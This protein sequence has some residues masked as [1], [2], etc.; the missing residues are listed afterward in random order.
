MTADVDDELRFHV[1]ALTNELVAGGMT[2]PAARAEALRRFGDVDRYR[3][4][5]NDVGRRQQ[6]AARF[7]TFFET[8]GQDVA[9]ATRTLVRAPLFTAVAVASLALGIGA[10]AAIF[11]LA[12]AILLHPLPAVREPER[13]ATLASGPQSYP[14]YRDYG[15]QSTAWEGL[16]AFRERPVSLGAGTTAHL[17]RVAIVSGNYFSVLGTP[18]LRG[19]TI[20]PDDDARGAGQRVAVISHGLWQREFA[21]DA[22]VLGRKLELNGTAFTVVGVAPAGFRGPRAVGDPSVWIPI[23]AWPSVATGEF[24]QLDIESRGWGWL[25]VI[26]RLRPGV[27]L[28]AADRELDAIAERLRRVHRPASPGPADLEL[29]PAIQTVMGANAHA[30]TVRFIAV[31]AA[32]AGIALLVACAN[33]ANLQ[34]ARA[35]A[36][37]REIGVRLALGAGRGRLVRQLVTENV[38]LAAL[39]GLA[40]IAVSRLML[41]WASVVSLPGG[42]SVA[43]VAGSVSPRV[44]AFTLAVACVVGVAFGLAP[45]LQASNPELVSALKDARG[46]S[47]RSGLKLRSA[48]V[49]SQ[50]ALCLVLLAGA[51]LF[52]RSLQRALSV[53]LGFRPAGVAVASF[54]LALQRYDSARAQAFYDRLAERMRSVPGVEAVGWATSLPFGG[55]NAIVVRPAGVTF[56]PGETPVIAVTY[57]AGDYFRALRIPI[58]RGRALDERDRAGTPGVAV[59]S[60]AMAARLWSG[61][62]PIGRQFN[63]NI[64]VVGVARDIRFMELR[65]RPEPYLYGS[66]PQIINTL[67]LEPVS[68]AVRASGDL[69]RIH[70]AIR[71]EVRALDERVPIIDPRSLEDQLAMV[72]LPQRVGAML[73][74]LFGVLT[75]VLAAVGVYGVLASVVGRRTREIGIRVALG[76]RPGQVVGMV[77]RQ[78]LGVVAAGVVIGI[79]LALSAAKAIASLLF[80]VAPADLPTFA[81]TAGAL[82]AVALAASYLP[83]RRAARVN[84]TEALRHE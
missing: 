53:D 50:I 64:T 10:N 8:I 66:L 31:L 44:L 77:L 79:V 11:S 65:G 81:A 83:A 15:D 39:G 30:P 1:E 59:I 49:A 25:S 56:P 22:S 40:A 58:V 20:V 48:L 18:A 47:A 13:L 71:R 75:L 42:V 41:R 62:D 14:N 24:L 2:P 67:G 34:L 4:A 5:L 35:A 78:S 28:T 29:R 27:G 33:V 32:V 26:G 43:D 45:A 57:V 63:G 23:N 17:A 36:R 55:D 38:V 72:L 51:G 16:A 21:G 7:D 46:A 52:L 9:F 54:H 80:G 84:P 76:A 61:E 74:G 73:L 60:A 68:L 6:R 70:A 69:D 82:V 37:A 12:D 3:A 19:R